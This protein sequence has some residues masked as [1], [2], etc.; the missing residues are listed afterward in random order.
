MSKSLVIVSGVVMNIVCVVG[1]VIWNKY[2]TDVDGFNFMVFLSFLHFLFTAIMMRVLLCFG[3]FT[4]APAPF[5]SVFPV[6]VVSVNCLNLVI[7]SLIVVKRAV[8][9]SIR[10][11]H[12]LES[13]TQFSWLLSGYIVSD[14]AAARTH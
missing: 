13:A 2:I 12:E 7:R 3:V 1:I 6:A 9:L 14:F 5:S 8:V 4:Y 10:W 11:I